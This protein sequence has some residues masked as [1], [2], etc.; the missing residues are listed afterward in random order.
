MQKKEIIFFVKYPQI[1]KVKTRLAANVGDKKAYDIYQLLLKRTWNTIK[2]SNL[3]VCIEYTP[4]GYSSEMKELFGERIEYFV[5]Q[6]SDIG[7][8]MANAF[9][10]VFSSSV[11]NA[12]L[13][14]SDLPDL[15]VETLNTAFR[16]LINH[17]VVIGPAGDGGYYLVGFQ[18][19]YFSRK[20]FEEIKWSSNRVY[21]QTIKKICELNLSKYILPER[22]DIDTFDDIN[23]FLNKNKEVSEFKDSLSHI[24][25]GGG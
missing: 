23:L 1:G 24:I 20:I 21:Q 10:R 17:E 8:R 11:D 14:G 5:Q 6:G 7:S 13:I 4:A 18:R 25:F 16:K 19:R 9:Q 2:Q 15:D 22:N 3:H 12:I